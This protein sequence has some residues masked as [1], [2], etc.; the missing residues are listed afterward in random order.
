[1]HS[2]RVKFTDLHI[3]AQGTDL[4]TDAPLVVRNLKEDQ[5]KKLTIGL[6]FTVLLAGTASMV[7]ANTPK[8]IVYHKGDTICVDDDSLDGHL[9]HGDVTFY[10]E[11]H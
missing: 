8:Y 7:F 2:A 5:M 4:A 6:L 1:V 9:G 11:C 10:E 3:T